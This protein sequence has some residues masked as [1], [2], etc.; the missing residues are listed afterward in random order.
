MFLKKFCVTLHPLYE[1]IVM[2]LFD[3]CLL[4]VALAMD[5][6]AVSIVSG[7]ILRSFFWS[8]A[9]RIALLFGAFQAF[10]PFLGWLGTNYFSDYIQSVDH[11]IAFGLLAFLGGKMIK[12][13]FTEEEECHHFNPR[14]LR[15]QIVLS[16]ATSIDAL[17]VG[18]SFACLGYREVGQLG[19]PLLVI[20]SVSFL[21]SV[22]G[23]ALGV[24]FGKTIARRLK[25]E[26][27]GGVILLLIGIKILIS[28]LAE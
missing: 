20:G 1:S 2:N 14:C 28:H 7:V 17:A 13:A 6:F 3:I 9:L 8:V 5:C 12:D 4:A 19:V 11:W 27:L 21:L 10:M 23:N 15:T 18:I 16:V 24:K 25:P 26:L 22:V